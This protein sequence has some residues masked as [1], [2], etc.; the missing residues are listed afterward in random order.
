MRIRRARPYFGDLHVHTA[1]SLDAARR[2]RARRPRDAYR[3]ARGEMIGLQP[4][5]AGG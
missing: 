5:D 1:F 2:A 4:F 3:F